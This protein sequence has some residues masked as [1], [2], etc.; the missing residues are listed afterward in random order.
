VTPRW[1]DRIKW[2]FSDQ[3]QRDPK[4]LEHS[5]M[6]NAD[7]FD[8][9]VKE[10]WRA[11]SRYDDDIAMAVDRLRPFGEVWVN[12]LARA[13]FALNENRE[14]LPSIVARLLSEAMQ[15]KAEETKMEAQRRAMIWRQTADGEICTDESLDILREAQSKDTASALR[16]IKHLLSQNPVWGPVIFAQIMTF[17]SLQNGAALGRAMSSQWSVTL[18]EEAVFTD[19]LQGGPGDRRA[20]PRRRTGVQG[21]WAGGAGRRRGGRATDGAG[22]CGPR[23]CRP[24]AAAK[25]MTVDSPRRREHRGGGH[26]VQSVPLWSAAEHVIKNRFDQHSKSLVRQLRIVASW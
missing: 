16:P 14:Y 19:M 24:P 11:L 3:M 15:L 4:A 5:I 21:P 1:R 13:Y 26:S 25:N 7:P 6:N 20:G 8:A 12:E 23:A 10:R 18:S 17:A 9:A 22:A 2:L